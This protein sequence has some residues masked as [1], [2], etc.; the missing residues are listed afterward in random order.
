MSIEMEPGPLRSLCESLLKGE[1]YVKDL[2]YHRNFN[3]PW[4]VVPHEHPDILQL[5]LSLNATGRLILGGR[6]IALKGVMAMAFHPGVTHGF[7][8]PPQAASASMFSLKLAVP[9]GLALPEGGEGLKGLVR[10]PPGHMHLVNALRRLHFLTLSK[11]EGSMLMAATA[12]EV[13]SLW[14]ACGG[15]M[16]PGG[17]IEGSES[18]DGFQGLSRALAAIEGSLQAPPGVESL[19]KAAGLS[20]RQLARR[21]QESLGMSPSDYC[22]RRRLELARSLLSRGGS[23]VTGVAKALG[24]PCIHSFSRWFSRLEGM[25]PS[26][27]QDAP[28]PL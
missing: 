16:L 25:P 26:K 23:T 21:F 3:A 8:L 1:S 19:A 2:N 7:F 13:V 4:T 22:Q 10:N 5:D 6:R 9:P 18:D 11:R 20:R 24:F 12:M 27:F 14:T 17:S 15:G 28:E